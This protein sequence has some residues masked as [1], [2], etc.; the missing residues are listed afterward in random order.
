MSRQVVFATLI[1]LVGIGASPLAVAAPIVVDFTGTGGVCTY[2]GFSDGQTCNSAGGFTGTITYEIVGP[3]PTPTVPNA[4]RIVSLNGWVNSSYTLSWN[5]GSYASAVT[6]G[7][8]LTSSEKQSAQVLDNNEG[9][10]DGVILSRTNSS[11]G[12]NDFYENFFGVA[13]MSR[14]LTWTNGFDFPTFLEMPPTDPI[15]GAI[16][17]FEFWDYHN[18]GIRYTGFS[19]GGDITSLT[20]R[21]PTTTVTEPASAALLTMGL[22]GFLL[23][24]RRRL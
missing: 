9:I 17:E 10:F 5:G 6:P 19:G 21:T 11:L 2:T 12:G 1:G 16:T 4:T 7:L 24:R 23:K 20:M 22:A 8:P 14:V 13:L 18:D 15:F 3:T